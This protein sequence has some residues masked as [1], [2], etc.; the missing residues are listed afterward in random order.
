[1]LARLA[2]GARWAGM[3]ALDLL[4]PP[5]CLTCDA[6]VDVP[7]RFCS[8]CFR[9]TAFVGEPCCTRCGTP[10]RHRGQGGPDG[11]CPSCTEDPPPW[12]RARVALRYDA[13]AR[14]V[15]L[16]LKYADRVEL[17]AALAPMMAR[18]GAALLEDA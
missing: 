12:T 1:M 13:Q 10:F 14:R 6:P 17:A 2:H 18:A 16:P 3:A 8:E 7:G 9:N 11:I 4:L 15:V 5:Q